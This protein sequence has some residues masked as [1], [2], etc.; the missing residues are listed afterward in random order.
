VSGEAGALAAR[1]AIAGFTQVGFPPPFAPFYGPKGTTFINPGTREVATGCQFCLG[2][3]FSHPV[4]NLGFIPEGAH[5]RC[6][7]RDCGMW[8]WSGSGPLGY[9]D[10]PRLARFCGARH[11]RD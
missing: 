7:C 1:G 10:R 4:G 11:R 9:L 6:W 8:S 2:Y 5:F 3:A